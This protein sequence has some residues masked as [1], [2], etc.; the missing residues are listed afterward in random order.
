M[1]GTRT[2]AHTMDA[3]RAIGALISG[4]MESAITPSIP[5]TTPPA[6]KPVL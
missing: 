6:K 5:S 3:W 1:E 2:F 4:S